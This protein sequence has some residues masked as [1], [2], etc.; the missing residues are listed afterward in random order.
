M[1]IPIDWE[2]ALLDSVARRGSGHTPDKT[3]AD[4]WDGGIKWISLA[5]SSKL[6]NRFINT[7]DKEISALGIRKSSAVLHSKGTV[8]LSRDAGVG[9]SAI[10]VDDMA[11][12]QHFITWKCDEKRMHNIFMYYWLQSKKPEFE[13]IATG[14][15]IKTI[16]LPYFKRLNIVLPPLAEQHKIAAIL[17]TWDDSLSTLARLI[18]TKRQQ[19]RALAE[20]LLT[21]KQRLKG[22]EGEWEPQPIG[23]LFRE[24][25]RFVDWDDSGQYI[26]AIVRRWSQGI[27]TR[28][29]LD[30]SDIK[31]KKL[32]KVKEGDFLV[33]NI[34]AA[35]GAMAQV[36]PAEAGLHVSNLY[37]ILEAREGHG[38]VEYL[39]QFSRISRMESLVIA[40]S[41]GFKA[42][43]VRLN[44]DPKVFLKQ[45][46]PV[47]PTVEEQQT[48]A[49]VLS[50]FDTEIDL[51]IRQQAKVQEQKRGL[52][53]LLLTGK[54]R[55]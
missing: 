18:D 9:K 31:V 14:S 6:D 46:I 34:Q 24:V 17:S 25:T 44:F 21:G 51:L 50:A 48:I 47:P 22:F 12:S 8:I 2:I 1:N 15:T 23:K 3:H 52:T 28:A 7:T 54:V 49:V 55:V 36:G 10:M 19:K 35:Y 40:S 13:S 53:E 5:D 33:S 29:E 39:D 4:Y 30:A 20:Q 38:S 37:T 45:I 16:G 32:Q 11:V 41:N 42:E 43:R 26:Q 27:T